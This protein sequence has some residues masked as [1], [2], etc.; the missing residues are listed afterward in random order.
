MG[1]KMT[2]KPRPAPADTAR[3]VPLSYGVFVVLMVMTVILVVAD[4]VKPITFA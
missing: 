3:M 2:G 1:A 4:L